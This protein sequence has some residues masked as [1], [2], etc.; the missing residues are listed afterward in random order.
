MVTTWGSNGMQ[1]NI[2]DRWLQLERL[3]KDYK[4]I[5]GR[6]KKKNFTKTLIEDGFCYVPIHKD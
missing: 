5:V 2:E 1:Q 4:M 6:Q 3:G